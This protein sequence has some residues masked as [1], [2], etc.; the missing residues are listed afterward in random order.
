MPASRGRRGRQMAE[1]APARRRVLHAA[2]L[3]ARGVRAGHAVRPPRAGRTGLGVGRVEPSR[4]TRS[5]C[6]GRVRRSNPRRTP[7]ASSSSPTR[8][9]CRRSPPSSTGRPATASTSSP[10][11]TSPASTSRC[12][13]QAGGRGALGAPRRAT[14]P[15]PRRSCSSTRWPRSTSIRP[16]P[17]C[18]A[19]ARAGR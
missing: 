15:A 12:P 1:A 17:T 5:R 6:G 16:V 9:G 2:R 11:A 18:G 14:R 8:P 4:A 19:A 13:T 3:A 7:P 10:S